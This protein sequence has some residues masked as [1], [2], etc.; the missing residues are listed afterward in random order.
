[1]EISFRSL[2]TAVHGILFG[3][4]F[5]FGLVGLMVTALRSEIVLASPSPVPRAHPLEKLYL[6][7]TAGLGWA[8]VLSGAYLV[9][10]WYRAVPPHGAASLA[11]YPQ[12]LL[13]AS[14]ATQQWHFIGMEWKEHIAWF[15]PM[16]MTMIAWV[17]IR[18]RRAIQ[19]SL[20]LRRA[21]LAFALA[22]FT[23]AGIAGFFG[24]MIDKYAPVSGGITIRLTG[25]K[26]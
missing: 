16:A 14:A 18:H 25:M 24:A 17:F 4:F 15:A 7:A 2:V 26:P 1:M 9:Y 22:A 6:I 23:A 11:P 19:E 13:R 5:L 10:P 12:A 21:L 3:G 20:H 8:A